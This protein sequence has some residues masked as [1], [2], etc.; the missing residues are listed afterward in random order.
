LNVEQSK[1]DQLFEA[2]PRRL[3]KSKH[4]E[5]ALNAI[6]RELRTVIPSVWRATLNRLHIRQNQ[7]ECVA[8]WC[9]RKTE[10]KPGMR[11]STLVTSVPEVLKLRRPVVSSEHR[12]ETSELKRV[13]LAE[14][15]R[16]WTAIPLAAQEQIVGVLTLSSRD[17]NVF[18]MD[19]LPFYESLGLAVQGRLIDLIARS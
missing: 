10:L 2:L 9:D 8:V 17:E 15:T 11:V 5:A 13:L 12:G 19:D 16:S 4:P 1:V 14:G 6:V 3:G 18:S 7:V